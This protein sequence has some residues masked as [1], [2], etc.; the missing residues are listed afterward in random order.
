NVACRAAAATA[1]FLKGA[2]RA[3]LKKPAAKH[4]TASDTA[5]FF[6][7]ISVRRAVLFLVDIPPALGAERHLLQ[8]V[9]VVGGLTWPRRRLAIAAR[10]GRV[11]A[12]LAGVE[13]LLWRRVGGIRMPGR[14]TDPNRGPNSRHKP[15][16]DARTDPGFPHGHNTVCALTFAH[17]DVCI[18]AGCCRRA[19]H[20]KSSTS[21]ASRNA[22]RRA[23]AR[24]SS[25]C[26]RPTSAT[27]RPWSRACRRRPPATAS[28]CRS[29]RWQGWPRPQ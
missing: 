15:A 20:H 4:D 28:S 22:R 26:C 16:R 25:Q 29:R 18:K 10:L 13:A 21:A 17:S 24:N 23:G 7:T 11:G 6:M 19:A 1:R 3:L 14:E 8:H 9:L 2:A 27:R 12:R 5:I